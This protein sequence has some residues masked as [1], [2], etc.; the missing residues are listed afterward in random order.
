MRATCDLFKT[1][2]GCRLSYGKIQ[3]I[4]IEASK[5]ARE[6]NESVDLLNIAHCALDEIFSQDVPVLT[7]IGLKT[8]YTFSSTAAGG[9]SGDD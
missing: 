9:R 8:G 1:L 3:R 7:V 5:K 4:I 6:F 2:Y